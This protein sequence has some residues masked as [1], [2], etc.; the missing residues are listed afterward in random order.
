M[1][2]KYEKGFTLIELL[3]VCAIIGV[4]ASIIYGSV[5]FA[6]EKAGDARTIAQTVQYR[7]AFNLILN[8]ANG[9][10]PNPNSSATYFCLGKTGSESCDFWGNTYSGSD[11]V[12][13]ALV[14]YYSGVAADASYTIDGAAFD[15]IVYKCKSITNGICAGAM[16]WAQ[17]SHTPCLDG[18]LVYQGN[19]GNVC[20]SN[21]SDSG[22]DNVEAAPSFGG[23]GVF[24]SGGTITTGGQCPLCI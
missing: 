18:I 22:T 11:A 19:G 14:S 1:K 3:F 5:V 10:L 13:N 2:F 17:S 24:G 21:A 16:Y 6:R 7:T 23:G 15:G 8:S 20:A 4:L 12:N 9:E